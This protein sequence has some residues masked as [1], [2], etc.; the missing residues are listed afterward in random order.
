MGMW[1]VFV[2]LTAV[3]LALSGCSNRPQIEYRIS[4]TA[5][6]VEV[7]YRNDQGDMVQERVEPPWTL[8]FR[9]EDPFAFELSAYGDGRSGT[10]AC[11]VWIN[12]Q[13]VGSAEGKS[14]A[15]C[16]G[17]FAQGVSHFRGRFDVPGE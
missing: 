17:E 16:F 1:K 13:E 15:E 11:A 10:V 14:Y 9:G 4:G 3:A 12:G 7:F 2:W 5:A 6:E 8:D